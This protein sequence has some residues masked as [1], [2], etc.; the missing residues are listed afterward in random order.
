MND[1]IV[2]KPEK[3]VGCNACIRSCPAPEAN[4]NKILENG[5]IITTVN[6]DKCIACGQ[7]IKACSHGARDY[8][9]DTRVC[10]QR[11]LKDKTIILVTPAIRNAFPNH[12]VGIL[13]WFKSKGCMIFDV[14]F[15]AD[16][17]TWAQLRSL[18][19]QKIGKIITQQC[20]AV[21]KYIETY[22]PS[23]VKNISPV[24]GPVAC[25]VTYIK[26]YLRRTNPIAVLTSCIAQKNEFAETG[27]VEYTVTFSKLK[28]YF[29]SNGIIIRTNPESE[30][31][32]KFDDIQGQ[33]GSI[34]LRPAG[35]KD[36]LLLHDPELN[37]YNSEGVHKVYKDLDTYA[38][39]SDIKRPDVFDVLSCQY[40][41]GLG[42]GTEN[43]TT[44]FDVMD[45]MRNLEKDAKKRRKTNVFKPGEDKLFK[46]FDDEFKVEDF[47]RSYEPSNP[48]PVPSEQQLEVIYKILGKHS[49][50]DKHYDCGACGYESC[51]DMATAICRGLN[52]ADNCVVHAKSQFN[53]NKKEFAASQ[54]RFCE[55]K[56]I[57]LSLS[58][59]LQSKM[60]GIKSNL[61]NI[62]E[63]TNK[64][65]ERSKVVNDLLT[66]II[67][68]CK[69]NDSLDSE[70]INQMI[71][72]LETT[73]K[74]FMALDEN[75]NTTN[76]NSGLITQ[77]VTEVKDLI[78][79]LNKTIKQAS[80]VNN[81]NDSRGE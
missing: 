31:E 35:I 72:I 16:I 34:Y 36:N 7:C 71:V 76:K 29:D 17:C 24:H 12:W 43:G 70:C 6:T 75:V 20:P 45:T 10:M 77:S 79:S 18:E 60:E 40:G 57:C 14:S 19:G 3:C 42:P 5:N 58:K 33:L 9:D 50:V 23:I 4:I 49:E 54:E 73:L 11:L 2:V 8:I 27:L 80:D 1:I 32:Y 39:I 53:Q 25:A 46:K 68:F 59:E 62:T 69:N 81:S 28:D 51:R 22:Q 47:M 63:S 55:N 61:A 26:K 44:A 66:N 67:T 38:E 52:I 30:F 13:D 48:S 15:G 64:T 37:I 21:V 56:D 74:A 78:D 65:S 41:C